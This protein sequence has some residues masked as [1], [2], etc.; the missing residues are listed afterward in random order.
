MLRTP[1]TLI[2]T[3]NASG[4]SLAS[5]RSS[6]FS[7]VHTL[8]NSRHS[9]LTANDSASQPS[10][11]CADLNDAGVSLH[12]NFGHCRQSRDKTVRGSRH[13]Q[14]RPGSAVGARRRVTAGGPGRS[15]DLDRSKE[16]KPAPGAQMLPRLPGVS[17][18]GSP[19]SPLSRSAMTGRPEVGG[20]HWR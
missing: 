16:N 19:S 11:R 4:V 14:F 6:A 10:R 8:G 9:S 7:V 12:P 1:Q 3:L 15:G 13:S 20:S 2:R 18:A 5:H 17:S